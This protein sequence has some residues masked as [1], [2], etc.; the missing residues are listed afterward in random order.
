MSHLFPSFLSLTEEKS[1]WMKLA[2]SRQSAYHLYNNSYLD[3]DAEW[4]MYD[5][6]KGKS[7]ENI[8]GSFPLLMK[9]ITLKILS[10]MIVKK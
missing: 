10:K 5:Y 4:G 3:P 2:N 1:I 7:E 6:E 9:M 8:I